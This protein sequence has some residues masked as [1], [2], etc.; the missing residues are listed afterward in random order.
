M[1]KFTFLLIIMLFFL[2]ICNIF[3]QQTTYPFEVKKT[4]KGNQSLIFI[5]GFASS[6][7]VWNETTSK[8]EKEFTCYTLTMAGFA[9]TKPQTDASFK[10]WEKEIAA[11]I[12]NNKIDK[13]ILIGHS[14]GGGL[15]LA[16]AAD[17]PE[18]IGK[19]I[20]VDTLP[21]L[22][23]LSDPNF[24]SKENNDCSA[25]ITQLTAMN[26]EQFRK[27][28]AQA[29][30]RLLADTSMQETVISWS[31]K[32]DRKT[33]A[34]M[35]CDFYNTDL[36]EKIK[37]IQCPS[38]ILLESFFVNLKSTIEGQYKNLKNANMQYASKG[39]HFIMYD[40]K[41]WYFNQLTHFLSAK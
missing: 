35:Y 12:R 36:R 40:D 9:G 8:F 3:G 5:P 7:D 21:C 33:F 31:M 32:S 26:D 34:K 18:L 27:M 41:D 1:K 28:Q 22:A 19:I 30:P 24:T 2:A 6:G 15:A 17:Y 20:I 39:L 13:P 29:M 25:T 11:Y 23:A 16:I 14:M 37:N 10:D 4:G 38:L